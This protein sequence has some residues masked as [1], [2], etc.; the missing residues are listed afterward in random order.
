[1]S[2]DSHLV[3]LGNGNQDTQSWFHSQETN[4]M[5]DSEHL[6]HEWRAGIDANQ[7][8]ARFG[9]LD[10]KDGIWRAP[11]G[12]GRTVESSGTKTSGPFGGL[13]GISGAIKRVRGTG[14]F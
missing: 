2:V 8:T 11:D 5:I 7:N 4:V 9:R 14:G 6:A 1:M 10:P 3:I 12:S 13:K